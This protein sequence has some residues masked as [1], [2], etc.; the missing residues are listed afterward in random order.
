MAPIKPR[1]AAAHLAHD[2]LSLLLRVPN[3]L[4]PQELYGQ[5][6]G[7]EGMDECMLVQEGESHPLSY[8]REQEETPSAGAVARS[9]C[10]YCK[11]AAVEADGNRDLLGR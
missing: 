8:V 7:T 6:G 3:H 2:C 10:C 4:W 1:S 9:G 5:G 11:G